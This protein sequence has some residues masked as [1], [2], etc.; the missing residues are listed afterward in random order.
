MPFI[1]ELIGRAVV[2][3]DGRKIGYFKDLVACQSG[4]IP[5]PAIV[6]LEVRRSKGSLL[7]PFPAIAVLTALTT[8]LVVTSIR[9]LRA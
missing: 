2:E 4:D 8:M 6:A 5:H 1:S 9:D 3:V 7:V